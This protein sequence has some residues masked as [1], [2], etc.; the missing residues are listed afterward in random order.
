M[1]S[2]V[3]IRLEW[4]KIE[5]QENIQFMANKLLN[6]PSTSQTQQQQLQSQLKFLNFYG[7]P[8][9]Q[10]KGYRR[11]TI[12]I[13]K[14]R[15]L[16]LDLDLTNKGRKEKKIYEKERIKWNGMN[17]RR[18]I[19]YGYGYAD[20]HISD[21]SQLSKCLLL[22]QLKL[23]NNL[24]T[25]LEPLENLINLNILDVSSNSITSISKNKNKNNLSST[26]SSISSSSSRFILSQHEKLTQLSLENNQIKK[27][28]NNWG[29]TLNIT[30]IYLGNNRISSFNDIQPIFSLPRVVIFDLTGNPVQLRCKL[31]MKRQMKQNKSNG[32][33][34]QKENNT[35]NWNDD[36]DDDDDDD[37]DIEY[38]NQDNSSDS[39]DNNN[40]Q[41]QNQDQNNEFIQTETEYRSYFIYNMLKLRVLDGAAVTAQ[42]QKD[43][44]DLFV[45]RLNDEE[46]NNVLSS[47]ELTTLTPQ[48]TAQQQ[49]QQQQYRNQSS[50]QNQRLGSSGAMKQQ[51]NQQ[52]LINKQIPS[53]DQIQRLNLSKRGL[54]DNQQ[55]WPPLLGE[56]N[57]S[58]NKRLGTPTNMQIFSE[59]SKTLH[60]LQYEDNGLKTLAP[61]STLLQIENLLLAGNR[62]SDQSDVGRLSHLPL[63]KLAFFTRN[64]L[65]RKH[66]YRLSTIRILPHLASLDGKC[67]TKDEIER[68]EY[69]MTQPAEQL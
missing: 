51:Y 5:S 8:I 54:R 47:S 66:N 30:E 27:L 31:N 58:R 26:Q 41:N 36:E 53:R 42:D 63:L 35:N 25:S 16:S 52:S 2:L 39:Q 13:F 65:A 62:L 37:V 22:E 7:N 23:E 4:N 17:T 43:A 18:N 57:L 24:L 9:C 14:Y 61:I 19:G 33:E 34:N 50:Q 44:K 20:N 21:I 10:V 49:L 59:M 15:L 6:N 46:L 40:E 29:Q 45:G 60:T 68:A 55:I 32:I 11:N 28:P 67:I 3:E 64:A 38:S 1:N 56:L 48:A 69:G 12:H